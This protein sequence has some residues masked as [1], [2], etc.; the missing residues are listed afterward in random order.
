MTRPIPT[1]LAAA[2]AISDGSLT[3]EALVRACLERIEAREP[4][5]HAWIHLASEAALAEA[6][7]LDKQAGGGLLK[8]I[9]IGVKDIIDTADMP[10][11]YGSTLYAGH[12][13]IRDASCVALSRSAG[14]I[15]LGKTVT[16]EFAYYEPGATA[17]PH[18]AD[19]SPGGSSSGSAAAVGD[20]MVPL[21]FGT[22]TAGSIIRPAS[23]CGCVGYKPSYGTLDLTGVRPLA[24]SLDTLGVMAA[25]VADAAFYVSVLASRPALRVDG[26]TLEKPRIG[27]WRTFEW[28]EAEPA[29]QAKFIETAERLKKAGCIVKDLALPSPFDTLA[30]AQWAIMAFEAARAV[31]P[32]M[33]VAPDKVSAIMRA[34][35]EDGRAVSID[36]YD[37][38]KARKQEGL[39]VFN[40][41]MG[42]LDVVLTLGAQGEA[43]AGLSATGDPIFNR[44]WTLLG[45]PCITLPC[46]V[47]AHG[48]PLGVQ[49][50]GRV[51]NDAQMLAAAAWIEQTLN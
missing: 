5:V 40:D 28:D 21:A 36:D 19:H 1:A 17:N 4:F 26:K 39:A 45:T 33:R 35:V 7:A 18:N 11:A 22:Q 32:E 30:K 15:I 25:D 27:L 46:G 23:F 20:G 48:L 16:T 31:H 12:R 6:R 2:R 8:G 24:V 43:P 49:I 13:P 50:V 38:Y 10:T 14:A 34:Y 37:A 41:A 44:I 47:G 29:M 51:G 3:A 9:P 42:D